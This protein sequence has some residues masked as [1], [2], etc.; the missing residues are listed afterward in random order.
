MCFVNKYANIYLQKVYIVMSCLC[1]VVKLAL[2]WPFPTRSVI[3]GERCWR[4]FCSA[5][6]GGRDVWH[7]VMLH[8]RGHG[9]YCSVEIKD[10]FTSLRTTMFCS[11]IAQTC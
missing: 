4:S 1:D 9:G 5:D 3:T 8:L 6:Q 7:A 10:L 2:K 11:A